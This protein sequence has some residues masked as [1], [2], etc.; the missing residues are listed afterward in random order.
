MLYQKLI[1]NESQ[2]KEKKAKIYVNTKLCTQMFTT[3]FIAP[4]QKQPKYLTTN[5]QMKCCED[6]Q[7]NII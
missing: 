6:M 3:F 4:K 2:S 7:W 5:K 1:P